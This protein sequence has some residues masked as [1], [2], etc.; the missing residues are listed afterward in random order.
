MP[1]IIQ[2]TSSAISIET[3]ASVALLQDIPEH[4]LLRGQSGTVVEQLAPGVV[5]V[6]FSDTNG[7]T[8]EMLPLQVEDL[9]VL[10]PAIVPQ[11]A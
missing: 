5:E 2:T 1:D 8:V 7:C 10:R 3:L 4:N 9:L 11:V 6:E